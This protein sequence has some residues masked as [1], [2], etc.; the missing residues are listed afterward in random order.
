M[1][2]VILDLN[3]TPYENGKK[4]GEYFYQYMKGH[5]KK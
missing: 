1:K 3:G 5:N 2:T 4:S